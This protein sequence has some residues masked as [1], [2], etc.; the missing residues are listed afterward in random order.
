MGDLGTL[1]PGL[2]LVM[3]LPLCKKKAGLDSYE[4]NT[5]SLGSATVD[6]SCDFGEGT[7]MVAVR[8]TEP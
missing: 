5:V 7:V 2:V 4:N 1:N 6:L 8:H 3:I